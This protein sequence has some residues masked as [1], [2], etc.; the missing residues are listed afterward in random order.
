MGSVRNARTCGLE[1]GLVLGGCRL[2]RPLAA[3]GM[4]EVWAARQLSLDRRVAV[5]ML[6]PLLSRDADYVERF[7]RE[8]RLAAKVRSPFVVQI[9]DAGVEHGFAYIVMELLEGRTLGARLGEAKPLSEAAALAVLS[10]AARGLAAAHKLG[11]VHRDVKPANIFLQ[12]KGPVKLLDFGIVHAEGGPGRLTEA[13]TVMGTPDFMSPE[14]CAGQASLPQS[15]LYSLGATVYAALAGRAPFSAETP[16]VVMRLHI[17]EDP[18]PLR[19]LRRDVSARTEALVHRLMAK[20]PEHRPRSAH[21]V[22]LEADGILRDLSRSPSDGPAGEPTLPVRRPFRAG[23]IPRRALVAGAATLGA[24]GVLSLGWAFFVSA[25]AAIAPSDAQSAVTRFHTLAARILPQATGGLRDGILEITI[26]PK[27]GLV[28]SSSHGETHGHEHRVAEYGIDLN[29]APPVR[30]EKAEISLPEI[31]RPEKLRVR[32]TV[33]P[34]ARR[35]K[36]PVR[37]TQRYQAGEVGGALFEPD[38]VELTIEVLLD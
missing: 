38:K 31:R 36:F 32:F 28:L 3:G 27:P 34:E 33:L 9:H 8:A 1:P 17:E 35:G 16:L 21:E 7:K 23:R 2:E 26:T 13:G 15:D 4:G 24:L 20:A 22:G 29:P 10:Q 6:S 11:L 37:I 30:L 12:R 25:E 18:R 19:E 14:Q 5:K